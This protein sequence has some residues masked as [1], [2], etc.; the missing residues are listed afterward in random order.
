MRRLCLN[1]A[2]S[3]HT[4]PR[5]KNMDELA[6]VCL[7]KSQA[8]RFS[9]E[10]ESYIFFRVSGDP[11]FDIINSDFYDFYVHTMHIE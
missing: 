1:V 5:D 8:Y 11:R 7:F 9:L 10:I 4:T 2:V 6:L 3:R